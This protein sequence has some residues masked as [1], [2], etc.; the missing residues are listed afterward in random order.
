MVL[1]IEN[2]ANTKIDL[3]N[4]P[5]PLQYF[6]LSYIFAGLGRLKLTHVD[7]VTEQILAAA[8]N[9]ISEIDLINKITAKRK[10]RTKAIKLEHAARRARVPEGRWAK[11]KK[12][13][14]N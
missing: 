11:H 4:M 1:N 8:A 14:R 10:R 7:E 2:A 5:G 6:E 9:Q 12:Q 3:F 13:K